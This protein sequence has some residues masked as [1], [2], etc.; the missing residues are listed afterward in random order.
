M[1]NRTNN[2]SDAFLSRGQR[3]TFN[4]ATYFMSMSRSG[5]KIGM[6]GF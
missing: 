1:A 4:P 6:E 5:E 2:D 3:F